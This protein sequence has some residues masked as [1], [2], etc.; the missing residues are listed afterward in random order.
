MTRDEQQEAAR[1]ARELYEAD[2]AAAGKTLDDLVPNRRQD[3]RDAYLEDCKRHGVDL[4]P[5]RPVK[6]M[7]ADLAPILIRRPTLDPNST[8]R[9]R[10]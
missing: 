9:P 3:A 6:L 10:P 1:R 5:A 7:P 2:L 8:G 4:S